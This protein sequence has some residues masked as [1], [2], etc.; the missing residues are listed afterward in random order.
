MRITKSHV[1]KYLDLRTESHETAE[2]MT[3]LKEKF[4]AALKEQNAKVIETPAGRVTLVVRE[5]QRL[6]EE[7]L[8]AAFGLENLDAF[9]VPSTVESVLVTAA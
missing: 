5:T 4:M 2:Y 6:D 3:E 1:Q 9:K 8:C 7:K